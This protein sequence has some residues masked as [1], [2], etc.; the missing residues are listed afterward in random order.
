MHVV[1][2]RD[3]IDSFKRTATGCGQIHKPSIS[4]FVFF[5]ESREGNVAPYQ[6]CIYVA[7]FDN[8]CA[9]ILNEPSPEGTIGVHLRIA[10][11][12]AKVNIRDIQDQHAINLSF[13]SLS[14]QLIYFLFE[15]SERHENVLKGRRFPENH[16]THIPVVPF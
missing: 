12:V 9:R 7:K 15:I 5:D 6:N 4:C 8:P 13:A 11:G 2:T 10:D 14:H 1:V 3:D 16:H